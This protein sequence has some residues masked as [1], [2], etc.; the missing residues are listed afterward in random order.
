M[1][2]DV[3]KKHD[4]F[5]FGKYEDA[6]EFVNRN[7]KSKDYVSW[8]QYSEYTWPEYIHGGVSAF[9]MKTARLLYEG[10]LRVK[11]VHLDYIFINGLVAPEVNATLLTNKDLD[12]THK[13]CGAIRT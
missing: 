1:L 8:D 6:G 11:P 7:T 4:N 13:K 12:F 2:E 9:P 3:G 5:I 10:A